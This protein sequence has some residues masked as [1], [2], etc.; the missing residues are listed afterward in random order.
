MRASLSTRVV[1]G[2][3]SLIALAWIGGSVGRWARAW[4]DDAAPAAAAPRPI[5]EAPRVLGREEYCLVCHA[6]VTGLDVSHRPESIGCASCHGGNVQARE[7]KLAH[8]GMIRIPG[9]LTDA[10]STCGQA[11]CHAAIVPRISRSIMTTMSGVIEVDRRVFG[12]TASADAPHVASLGRSAADSHLRQLCASCHLGQS[13][14][15]WGP[16]A[17]SSRGGG[18]NACHLQYDSLA[19]RQLA[20]YASTAPRDR[21]GIP[22]RHPSFTIAVDNAKCFGCHSRSGRIS[23][24]YEG[25]HEM[26]EP[27]SASQLAADHK[28]PVPQYRLLADGRYFTRVAPDVHQARGM[29]CVDCHT[30][31]EVMGTGAPVQHARDQVQIRCEDCHASRLNSVPAQHADAET[32]RL[33]ALRG[34]R[35]GA[36]D[37]LGV[38]ASGAVLSNVVVA[39]GSPP[40]LRRKLSGAWSPLRAP[41]A[42]CT[43]GAGHARL[44][45]GA[46][47]TAWAPTCATC[48]TRFEP[49]AE[50]FDH[51]EQRDVKGAW[52]ESAGPYEAAPPTLGIRWDRRD[53]AHP[54]GVVDTFVPG[55]ILTID[56][57]RDPGGKP[58]TVFRR[59]YARI[60]PHTT[61]RAARS[62]RSCHA[63]PVALGYGRGVLRFAASGSTGTWS[64]APSA[65][66]AR[67][68]LPADAWTGFLQ[69]RR[70]MVSTRDDVRPFTLDE[71]RRIL[72]VGACLTC[73]D[74]ASSVMQRAISDFAA[75]LARRTG[76][77]AVPRWPAR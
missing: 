36:D 34:W 39:P 70:G 74:G 46:C 6:G 23:T 32:S 42:V 72:T 13:K 43:Q 35:F 2:A 7:A 71:Q 51:V 49:T 63:D 33:H 22:T 11:A 27:P 68:G 18:C 65:K 20:A 19:V 75:T 16:V 57:N 76:A 45:C 4:R 25:W 44:T 15:Q 21:T 40:R 12:D 28:A 67:D 77:C 29:D 26:A 9:N 24:S 61:A 55:M 8:E 17:E 38:S 54:R 30:A 56:R 48:H 10:A 50:G 37:R 41:R 64:F 5:V 73:H 53:A 59:L 47:H 3:A 52:E 66:P 62:C 69:A 58:D 14:T 60:A 31:G 1:A